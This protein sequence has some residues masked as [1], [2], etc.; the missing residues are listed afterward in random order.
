M[1][2]DK[3]DTVQRQL[4]D[5]FDISTAPGSTTQAP[6]SLKRKSTGKV[7]ALDLHSPVAPSMPLHA[8]QLKGLVLIDELLVRKNLGEAIAKVVNAL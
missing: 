1:F 7:T 4:S 5:D 2:P 3:G 6:I 8:T